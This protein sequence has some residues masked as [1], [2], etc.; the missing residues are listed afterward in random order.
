MFFSMK[1]KVHHFLFVFNFVLIIKGIIYISI[2][3]SLRGSGTKVTEFKK[4]N[5]LKTIKLSQYKNS[6]GLKKKL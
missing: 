1:K 4:K 5:P 3:V 6:F 2:G